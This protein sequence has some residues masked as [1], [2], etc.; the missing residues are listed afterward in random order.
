LRRKKATYKQ[1]QVESELHHLIKL[2]A[3]KENIQIRVLV[4]AMLQHVWND[5]EAMKQIIETLKPNSN[6]S[7]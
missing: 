7:R 3:I 6:F 5:K 4:T 2:L 1:A